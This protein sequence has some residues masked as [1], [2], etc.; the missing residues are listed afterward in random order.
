MTRLNATFIRLKLESPQAQSWVPSRR[1][2]V[3]WTTRLVCRRSIRVSR[4]RVIQ[5]PNLSPSKSYVFPKLI[6]R[7]ANR[8][9][10]TCQRTSLVTQRKKLNL[11]TKSNVSHCNIKTK[12]QTL[13]TNQVS[14]NKSIRANL[15]PKPIKVPLIRTKLTIKWLILRVATTS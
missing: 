6:F 12:K 8:R 7:W 3:C 15:A 10:T 1:A 4:K 13:S 5:I 2:Q 14:R 9:L 11:S